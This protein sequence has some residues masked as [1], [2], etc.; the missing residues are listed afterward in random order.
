MTKF[1]RICKA[2]AL[3]LD[4]VAAKS[5]FYRDV[6]KYFRLERKKFVS[7]VRHIECVGRLELAQTTEGERYYLRL[8]LNHV[9]GP[10]GYDDLLCYNGIRYQTFRDSANAR[11]LLE[12]DDHVIQC[13]D[14]AAVSATGAQ[15]RELFCIILVHTP[16]SQPA[17]L[18]ERFAINLSDDC[19]WRIASL[20]M[21]TGLPTQ[22]E[23]ENYAL[24][25]M[26]KYLG[27]M[28]KSLDE[29][30]LPQVNEIMLAETLRICN[31]PELAAIAAREDSLAAYI[32]SYH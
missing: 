21:N 9:R 14:K 3:G 7:R 11:G 27:E 13:L 24:F 31:G 8:L 28:G 22:A 5:L 6:A 1:F 19:M 25:E 23:V 16:P 18:W 20:E 2:G 4:G 12:G 15:L 26:E 29:V 17:A 30:G 10:E 32:G